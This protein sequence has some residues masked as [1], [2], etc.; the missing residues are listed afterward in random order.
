MLKKDKSI[1]IN[2]ALF[3]VDNKLMI[4]TQRGNLTEQSESQQSSTS[5]QQ[6]P[7]ALLTRLRL[8]VQGG[9]AAA[10]LGPRQHQEFSRSCSSH[11]CR[12][13]QTEERPI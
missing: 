2:T 6:P 7:P 1:K 10:A 12:V 3:S 9:A 4:M 8:R 5:Q 13:E 11:S